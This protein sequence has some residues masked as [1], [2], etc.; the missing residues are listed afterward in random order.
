[1]RYLVGPVALHTSLSTDKKLIL[2]SDI[3]RSDIILESNQC[4]LCTNTCSCEY[5]SVVEYIQ[6]IIS[7]TSMVDIYVET[8]Y[9]R[10]EYKSGILQQCKSY[11]MLRTIVRQ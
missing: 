11:G 2:I 6:E 3:H 7:T 5:I 10:K 9:N 4:I 1:M 8:P